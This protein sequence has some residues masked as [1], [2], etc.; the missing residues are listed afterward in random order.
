MEYGW[1]KPIARKLQ[2]NKFLG[3]GV[4]STADAPA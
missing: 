4:I 2:H 3:R 1:L